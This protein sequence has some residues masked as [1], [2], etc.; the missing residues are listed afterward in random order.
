MNRITKGRALLGSIGGTV[1]LPSSHR[2]YGDIRIAAASTDTTKGGIEL[3]GITQYVKK[4]AL[5]AGLV[6][7]GTTNTYNTSWSLPSK[8]I[9]EDAW[10]QTVTEAASGTNT[11]GVFLGV[12]PAANILLTGV[13]PTSSFSPTNLTYGAADGLLKSRS[14]TF[15]CRVPYYAN[16]STS[17]SVRVSRSATV[18]SA[19]WVGNLFIKYYVP[20]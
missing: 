20:S 3:G 12:D 18:F 14:T 10:I 6:N 15:E 16:S 4:I 13:E 2:F 8:S 19:T 11:L 17:M 1:T 5:T 9:V 7:T